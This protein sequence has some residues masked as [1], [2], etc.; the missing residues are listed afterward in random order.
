MTFCVQQVLPA[1]RQH[2]G[3]VVH[4][5]READMPRLLACLRCG[6]KAVARKKTSK[7]CSLQCFGAARAQERRA[8][9]KPPPPVAGAIWLPTSRR[10]FVLVDEVDVDKFGLREKSIGETSGYASI[11]GQLLHRIL[12]GDPQ[13]LQVD[14][15]NGDPL[16]CR[17]SNLRLVTGAQ[18]RGNTKARAGTSRF[19]GVHRDRR[20]RSW[21]AAINFGGRVR[22]LGSF[23]TEEDAARA[24]DAAARELRRGLD[25][26]NFPR[27]GEYSALCQT[28][29]QP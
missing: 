13:S 6:Q 28:R 3:S 2:P 25:R 29:S 22:R 20:T 14:H 16:D 23:A 1:V 9:L 19:K 17:R 11:R 7:F 15:I 24:Y 5:E 12:M 8:G 4:L 21:T 27:D 10:R 18:N 26:L